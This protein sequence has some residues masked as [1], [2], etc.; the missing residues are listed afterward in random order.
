NFLL[1]T[2]SNVSIL[3]GIDLHVYVSPENL[4]P[5]L[6]GGIIPEGVP[7]L[8]QEG[9]DLGERM[10]NVFSTLFTK[11]YKEVVIIGSDSPD[12][13]VYMIERAFVRIQKKSGSI[14][15]GPA[16]DGG[17]YLIGMDTLNETVF[18]N[19]LWSTDKVLTETIKRADEA[20]L[21]IDLLDGWYD[22]D[23]KEDLKILLK[24][25]GADYSVKYLE[26]INIEEK[27][28]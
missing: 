22:I 6:L 1:D 24:S 23:T 12:L 9:E 20:S 11:G 15:V 27:L 2:F 17:Y 16:R 8:M 28:K 7:S 19:I 10:I 3:N 5:D 26:S 18:S 25:R 14:V 13:P 21:S 4:E